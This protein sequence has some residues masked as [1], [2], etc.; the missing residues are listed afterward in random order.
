MFV[1]L[2]T[3]G[4]T[5]MRNEII[6]Y[7]ALFR[8]MAHVIGAPTAPFT[9]PHTAKIAMESFIAQLKTS[10]TSR[11]VGANFLYTLVDWPLLN[12]SREF[13]EAGAR[14]M[15]GDELCDLLGIGKPGWYYK[16]VM[17]G[18][19]MTTAGMSWAMRAVPALD[20]RV[21]TVSIKL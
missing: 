2:P 6:D 15:N 21:I 12:P 3:Q 16:A 20:R 5:P 18:H 1:H 11:V 7:I 19:C 9:N 13:I 14:W 10:P 4:V 8:Y 17:T